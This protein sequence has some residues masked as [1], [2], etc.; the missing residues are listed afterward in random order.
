MELFRIGR[1]MRRRLLFIMGT[2]PE[3]IKLAP[4]IKG[5]ARAADRW[6]WRICS[7][8]QHDE[9]LK[10][11]CAL[12]GIVPD[13]E[14][15]VMK[16]NQS[17]EDL[18]ATLMTKLPPVIRKFQ[19]QTVIVQGDTTT[20]FIGALSAF[21]AKVPVAHVEAG[22]RTSDPYAPF[23]EE[24]NRRMISHISTW[25]FAPT[26]GAR[27]NLLR[28]GIPDSQIFLVGN[29]VVDALKA[30]APNARPSS[31][32][33]ERLGTAPFILVTQHR[34]ENFGGPLAA[35]FEALTR[36]AAAHPE[37]LL[38]YPVHPNPCVHDV[39]KKTFASTPNMRLLPPLAYEDFLFLM[40]HATLLITDSGGIQ[41]EAAALG[42]P[43]IV[44]REKT[45]RPEILE[46][47][48]ARVVGTDPEKIITAC[49]ELL[50]ATRSSHDSPVSEKCPFG[51]GF[52]AR[53]IL[54]VLENVVS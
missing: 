16:P 33:L 43:L 51:D 41:E 20:A 34:R 23:P 3:A 47:S 9:L 12:F 13:F 48:Y 10:E 18:S 45:E 24:I 54:E 15:R 49:E 46:L 8:G 27:Q 17:L 11:A 39:A 35:I 32:E 52:A 2:R 6:E 38:V 1:I 50:A 28:E 26:E 21:Y 29:T 5:V 14:L 44:T 37:L 31:K 7:T 25:H 42:K 19:P 53:R 22:L 30:I 36:I 40:K 4:L